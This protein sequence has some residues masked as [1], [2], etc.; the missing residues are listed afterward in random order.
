MIVGIY[1]MNGIDLSNLE[2]IS[3]GFLIVIIIMVC[4]AIGLPIFFII[5]N[6]L[7]REKYVSNHRDTGQHKVTASTR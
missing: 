2:S 7:V 1:G 4:I 5:S 3:T 6:G